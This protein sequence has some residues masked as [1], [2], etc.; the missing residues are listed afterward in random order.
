MIVAFIPV[1]AS[2]GCMTEDVAYPSLA[3]L[4]YLMTEFTIVLQVDGLLVTSVLPGTVWITTGP[5]LTCMM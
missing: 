2:F 3:R 4:T 1:A 5:V